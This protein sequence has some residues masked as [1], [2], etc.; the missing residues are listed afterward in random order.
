MPV[1]LRRRRWVF[2][3]A[4]TLL[5]AFV[6]AACA[7]AAAPKP[8]LPSRSG[9]RGQDPVITF[10]DTLL[11]QNG[12]PVINLKRPPAGI[13]AAKG[14][15]KTDDTNAFRDA[16]DFLKSEFVKSGGWNPN[17]YYVYLPDGTYTVSDTL[18]Y[19]G[20]TIQQPKGQW[21]G[22][23]FD[24]N[25]IRF[26][27]QSRKKTIIRL[28][29]R[30]PG[31]GDPTRPKVLMAFQH[32]DTVFNNVPGGNYL[33]NVTLSTGRGNGGAIGL[34]FQGANQS[35][36]R[37][38]TVRSED[39]AGR[40]GIWFKI[41]SVQGYYSDVTVDG[42]DVGIFDPVNAEGDPAFEYLTLKNQRQTGILL[43]GGGMSLRRVLSEQTGSVPAL[44]MDGTGTQAVVI[45]SDLRG[46][47]SSGPAAAIEMTT[48]ER[49]CLFARNVLTPGYARAVTRAGAVAVAGSAIDEYVSHPA[50]ALFPGQRSR[51]LRLPIEDT[52][53]VPWFDPKTQ[54]AIVDDYPS[55]QA[56]F[57]SGKPVVCFK[58]RRYQLS[59]DVRVP[60]WVKFVNVLAANVDGGALLVDRS[61]AAPLLVQ[62]SG[63]SIQVRA[64]RN[65][66]QRCA[67]GGISN[68]D[69]LPV[70]FFLENV[71]DNTTGDNFCRPGQKV[72][73]R[74][75]DIE[76]G[77]GS[78]I[79]SNGGTLWIFG[80]KTENA[81]ATP[82]TAKNGGFLEI[83]GGYTNVT[84]NPPAD[85]P[86]RHNPL[87]FNDNGHVSATLFTNLGGP[88]RRTLVE[89][90]GDKTVTATHADFPR[91]G[92]YAEDYVVALYAGYTKNQ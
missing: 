8:A 20:E 69:G 18:I 86:A 44:K 91:R 45:D 23:N 14:D 76:Y 32:L 6:A 58:K 1:T 53:R 13:R 84:N 59:G 37:G 55:V 9:D 46:K 47:N 26:V 34:Y 80:Y 70:T 83:L 29:D 27:G 56:A 39:G 77:S 31:Y 43:T 50:T 40:Y 72:F 85:Q 48:G 12:G 75:I 87:I 10:P 5:V 41:G 21:R 35:D 15:G 89:T 62:D 28:A 30:S 2:A 25:H 81:G 7:R 78:Q 16:Y 11:V 68:P 64:R 88:W 61:S 52:P 67:G 71:N 74:Q 49:Q 73:A 65:V 66:I 51:S 60:A 36:L 38:V 90:R 33:R 17:V 4:A 19:R 92:G 82:F 54:W 57:D 63:I 42:F 22:G 24:F 79:V 3:A